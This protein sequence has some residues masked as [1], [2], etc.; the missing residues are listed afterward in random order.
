MYLM[1]FNYCCICIV[2]KVIAADYI[3]SYFN[4]YYSIA[5]AAASSKKK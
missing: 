3:F 4:L 2:Q 1:Y 5:N